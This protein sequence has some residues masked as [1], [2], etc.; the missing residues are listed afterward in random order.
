MALFFAKKMVWRRRRRRYR[1]GWIRGRYRGGVYAA[2]TISDFGELPQACCACQLPQG[3]SLQAAKAAILPTASMEVAERRE[4][5]RHYHPT[6]F[7]EESPLFAEDTVAAWTPPLQNRVDQRRI[8]WRRGRRRYRTGWI[9][10]R[11]RG[12]VDAAATELAGIYR[13]SDMGMP[14][15]RRFDVRSFIPLAFRL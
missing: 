15:L 14:Q 7:R 12:G 13:G 10:G 9:R 11:Y 1:T 3:G 8:P 4:A 5:G 6:T 2:A